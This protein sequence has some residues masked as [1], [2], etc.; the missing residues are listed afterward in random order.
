MGDMVRFWLTGLVTGVVMLASGA[1]AQDRDALMRLHK[2]GVLHLTAAATA[3]SIDP[4][5]AYEEKIYQLTAF[6]YDGLVT[7]RKT[8]GPRSTDI[9][10]DLAEAMPIVS[11]GGKTYVFKLRRGVHFSTG[12]EV[13]V[14]DVVASFRRMFKVSGPNVGTWYSVLV[15][16]DACLKTPATCT[17][18]GGVAADPATNTVTLHLTQP[19]GAFLD[20]LA[21]NFASI[22]PA[23]L[24]PHDVGTH[25]AVTTGPYMVASYDPARAMRMV[26]NP[27]FHEWSAEAQPAGYPDEIVY[28]F[29]LPDEAEITEVENGQQDWMFDEK[30]LDRLQELGSQYASLVHIN[31]MQAY[32][33]LEMNTRLPPFDNAD[34]RRAVAYAV[35]R[36]SLV[37]LFG[38]PP[39]GTPLCQ[40]LPAGVA[41]YVPYCPFTLH[42]GKAWTAPDL[43]KARALVKQSGTEGMKVTLVT[44]DKEVERT[45]GIY[46]QSVLADIGYQ[47]SVHTVSSA[48]Q[49][50]YFQNSN[51][52]VQ[53][54]LTDWFADFPEASDFLYVMLSCN[55]FHPGS[56]ASI[57]MAAYCDKSVEADMNTALALDVT[58][59]AAAALAWAKVD[60]EVTD[61]APQS[62]LFQINWLD[63]LSPR[64]GNF[65][66]SYIY[67]MLFSQAW[68]R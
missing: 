9:V 35:N 44:S 41:G 56:D 65:Q 1:H 15:G 11:D 58:D 10:P 23:D 4:Q 5:I 46:L 63:L 43:A 19:S 2:G 66:F 14:R 48:I 34:A 31:P 67:R 3:S 27:Y 29:G 33:Y 6:L 24:A 61:A 60:R 30:P 28:R 45:M 22:L 7:F 26:R 17:L 12:Q 39:L 50:T 40:D 49:F 54:G 20:E 59:R 51:N 42:P 68:V 52:R 21:I 16:A 62:T 18:E 8:G 55:S 57:N 25:P 47:A 32:F 64:V 53:I 37:N 36:K 38:G 13:T